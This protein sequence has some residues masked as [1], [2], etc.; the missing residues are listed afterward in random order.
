ML[1]DSEEEENK[2]EG[3]SDLGLESMTATGMAGV[4]KLRTCGHIFCRKE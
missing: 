1:E 4:V 3:T 2:Q